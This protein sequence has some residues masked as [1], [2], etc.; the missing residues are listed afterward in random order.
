MWGASEIQGSP[1]RGSPKSLVLECGHKLRHRKIQQI[2]KPRV[3]GWPGWS[4]ASLPA[5]WCLLISHIPEEMENPP[6]SGLVPHNGSPGL[7]DELLGL[8][9]S[10]QG[11]QGGGHTDALISLQSCPSLCC[12]AGRQEQKPP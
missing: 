8:P 9:S 6:H 2:A 3:G 5:L 1:G 7:S 11:L 12:P 10:H 4:P